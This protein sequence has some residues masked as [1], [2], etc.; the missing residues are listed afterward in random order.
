MEA[1]P[2]AEFKR[3]STQEQEREGEDSLLA[4]ILEKGIAAN[5]KYPELNMDSMESFLQDTDCVRYPTRIVF[6]Y[7]AEMAPHQFAQPEKDFRADHPHAKVLYLRPA[8]KT[9]ERMSIAAIA[10]M[11]PLLNYG[12]IIRDEHCLVF[13]SALLGIT[14]DACYS[15]ICEVADFVGS[16]AKKQ[17]EVNEF[18]PVPEDLPPLPENGDCGCGSGCGCE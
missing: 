7:G 9:Q 11:L 17:S 14:E 16:E 6:E 10:Y 8:L 4:H 5:A 12:D 3:L 18:T 1:D 15:L 2:V 13:A